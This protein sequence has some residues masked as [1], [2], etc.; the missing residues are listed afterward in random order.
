MRRIKPEEDKRICSLCGSN[1]TAFRKDRNRPMW[2]KHK[3]TGLYL[4]KH[5]YEKLYRWPR[6]SQYKGRKFT[7]KTRTL[8]GFCSCCRNNVLDNTCT[9]TAMAHMKYDD[10]DK[11]AHRIEMCYP[12]HRLYDAERARTKRTC[13]ICG[14][15][16]TTGGIIKPSGRW[17]ENWYSYNKD[18][19]APYIC[20]HCYK[21]YKSVGT[22]FNRYTK[23][24]TIL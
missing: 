11:A 9:A 18:G 3:E 14:S 6:Q 2:H 4:C 16:K 22:S 24:L 10:N 15:D 7:N 17:R 21:N 23:Y 19:K 1:T 12:C 20:R 8:T 5:C 13:F